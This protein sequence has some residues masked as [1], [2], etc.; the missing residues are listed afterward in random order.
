MRDL[1]AL[2]AGIK[3]DIRRAKAAE[4]PHF[5]KVG[6]LLAE[7]EC[8]FDDPEK[9]E[10]WL[11]KNFNLDLKTA[12][13]YR[14]LAPTIQFIPPEKQSNGNASA[15][16]EPEWGHNNAQEKRPEDPSRGVSDHTPAKEPR[17]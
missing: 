1:E 7:A 3:E 15:I 12:W 10:K 4:L 8:Q 13:R 14:R 2:T 16:A 6:E 17:P 11:R 9:W 5:Q